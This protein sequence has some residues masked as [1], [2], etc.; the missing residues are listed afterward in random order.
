M[1][2]CQFTL[3]GQGLMPDGTTRFMCKGKSLY[4]FMGCST[5]SEY[6]VVAEISIAKVSSFSLLNL[7]FSR[8]GWNF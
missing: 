4:H 6:T 7:I 1:K 8:S 3:Q 2:H 5:F